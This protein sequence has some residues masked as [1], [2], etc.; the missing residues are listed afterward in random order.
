MN[1]KI[2]IDTNVWLYVFMDQTSTKHQRAL[3]IVNKPFV[4]LNTQVIKDSNIHSVEFVTKVDNG[5]F[6]VPKDYK[7]LQQTG[8]ARVIVLYNEC[9]THFRGVG[10][11]C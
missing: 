1:G 2:F 11:L 4:V 3:Y 9:V 8:K 7:Q 10:K 5:I 6:H